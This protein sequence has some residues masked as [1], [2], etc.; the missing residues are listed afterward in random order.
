MKKGGKIALVGRNGSG[1]STLVKLMLRLYDP[2]EGR[3]TLDGEDIRN[4]SPKKYRS[5]FGIVFQE[6]RCFRCRSPKMS[7]C[8][9]C[10]KA[11]RRLLQRR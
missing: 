3:I 7:S 9:R 10:V 4:I 6:C 5:M 11:T 2:T 8:A 1:K